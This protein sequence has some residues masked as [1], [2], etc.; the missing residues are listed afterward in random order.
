MTKYFYVQENK[1]T[2]IQNIICVLLFHVWHNWFADTVSIRLVLCGY[3]YVPG[4]TTS[5]VTWW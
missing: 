2:I 5:S 3:S 1:K 4:I